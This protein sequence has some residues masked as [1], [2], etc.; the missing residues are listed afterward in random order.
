MSEFLK[1]LSYLIFPR[2]CYF[3]GEV[4]A[5]HV[6][7][8]KK[9]A[10]SAERVSKPVCLNCGSGKDRCGCKGHRR[11][12][13]AAAAPFYYSGAVRGCIIRFKFNG[14][15]DTAEGLGIEMS[16]AVKTTLAHMTFDIATSVPMSREKEKKRGYNQS[17]LLCTE[18][19]KRLNID[20]DCSLLIKLY[21]TKNQHDLP[22][23]LRSGNIFGVFD[24]TK[25]EKVR[26]K[27]V[28]LCDD[29]KTSGETLN[30]CAK[31]LILN[32]A[33]EVA[34][35]CAAVVP[36]KKKENKAK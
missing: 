32:G 18:T 16:K 33:K 29:I 28:L 34:C 31:M 12:F 2:R 23:H 27:T 11:F 19:A 21:E 35:V 13:S 30:E 14:R 4:V 24:V 15:R 6:G 5:P 17:T 7:A 3:C 20:C 26:G 25:P 36:G 1:Q 8:C 10:S 9:C 22:V